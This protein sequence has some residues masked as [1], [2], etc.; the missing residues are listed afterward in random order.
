MS[1]QL[2]SLHFQAYRLAYDVAK[3]AEAAL[4]LEL[5]DR[6]TSFI[7]FGYWDTL[8]KG[9]LAGERLALDLKRMEAAYLARNVR[10]PELTRHVSLALLSPRELLRLKE[11]GTCV[12]DLPEALFDL[13]H[14]GHYLRRIKSL[15]L[16]IPC[17]TGPYVGVPCKLT[18][19]KS[20]M[21][22]S[23]DGGSRYRPTGDDD[24][25][26]LRIPPPA[27]SLF[28]SSAQGDSG[29]FETNLRDERF[30]PF[31]GYGAVSTWQLDLPTDFR[32]FDYDTISDVVLHV[33]YTAKYGGDA[34]KNACLG[35][36][37]DALNAVRQSEGGA[38][39]FARLFA[40]RYEIPDRFQAFL[41][42]APGA[43]RHE[44]TMPVTMERFPFL[45][46]DKTVRPAK[47]EAFLKVQAP[48]PA[49]RA[50]IKVAL[51]PPGTSPTALVVTD[52]M[53]LLR[54]EK[55]MTTLGD[56]TLAVW[57]DVSGTS[58]VLP[59]DVLLEEVFLI[60]YYQIG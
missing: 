4:R 44:I 22:M 21:R 6:D 39:G 10:D 1:G 9:L 17:V 3:R 26:V 55:P 8:K 33:R 46:Q 11:L 30:L 52:D 14:P 15:S 37:R 43:N 27:Q 24:A 48:S 28:L 12:I 36:L 40:L 38:T 16:T 29:L 41:H 57:Q 32:P 47:L 54:A 18:L 13:D 19:L 49:A 35:E 20:Q 25:R 56:W 53:G 23:T 5:A 59:A 34:L 60:C 2:S 50:A 45:V 7:Q 58:Q 42:A 31:E 51:D